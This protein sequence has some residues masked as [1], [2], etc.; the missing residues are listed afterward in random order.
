MSRTDIAYS[1]SGTFVAAWMSGD[2]A[3]VARSTDAGANW[4]APVDFETGT[5]NSGAGDVSIAGDSAAGTWVL[6][7]R[8]SL[9][10]GGGNQ[11]Y[12]SVSVRSAPLSHELADMH[13]HCA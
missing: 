2:G 9:Q 12:Y 8:S 11:L 4:S 3:M 5:D 1:P 7:W 13:T 6:V 10:V